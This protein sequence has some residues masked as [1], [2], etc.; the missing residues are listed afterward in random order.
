MLGFSGEIKEE[1]SGGTVD[2]QYVHVIY[3]LLY[4]TGKIGRIKMKFVFMS[5]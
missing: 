5:I 4:V 1:R 3:A 2:Y